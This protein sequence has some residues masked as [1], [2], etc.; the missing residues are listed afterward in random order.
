MIDQPLALPISKRSEALLRSLGAKRHNAWPPAELLLWIL[1][2]DAEAPRGLES[3]LSDQREFVDM[4]LLA[5]PDK[6]AAEF[7]LGEE[8]QDLDPGDDPDDLKDVL[9]QLL[10]TRML[11]RVPGYRPRSVLP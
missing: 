7:L 1:D 2:Y 6:E 9:L 10:H 5:M 3:Y 4:Q 8:H 11:E